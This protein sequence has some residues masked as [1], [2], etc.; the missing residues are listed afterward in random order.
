MYAPRSLCSGY[1]GT[2]EA[3]QCLGHHRVDGAKEK[4]PGDPSSLGEQGV[5]SIG[6]L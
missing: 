3:V 1:L 2:D 6:V 4:V 5:V